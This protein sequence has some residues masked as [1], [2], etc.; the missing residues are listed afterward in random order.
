MILD[1]IDDITINQFN[2]LEL[3]TESDLVKR[4]LINKLKK[5]DKCVRK[6]IES[7]L[8]YVL[9]S[10]VV[11]TKDKYSYYLKAFDGE[12]N[13]LITE[14]VFKILMEEGNYEKS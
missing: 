4:K 12:Y 8:Y 6:F 5:E 9:R 11:K 14:E 7:K 3:M 13:E 10:N 2:F 1:S